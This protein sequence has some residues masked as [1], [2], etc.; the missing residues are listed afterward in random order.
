[1]EPTGA[2]TNDRRADQGM[3]PTRSGSTNRCREYMRWTAGLTNKHT[4]RRCKNGHQETSDHHLISDSSTTAPVHGG[5]HERPQRGTID[6]IGAPAITSDQRPHWW[7][8][9]MSRVSDTVAQDAS[10][11]ALPRRNCRTPCACVKRQ[12]TLARGD[13]AAYWVQ[14]L[15]AQICTSCAAPRDARW[16]SGGLAGYENEI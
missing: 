5:I 14:P 12:E 10:G 8:L 9:P 11:Q 1:M 4:T 7:R 15:D 16:P 13:R 2:D 6:L 3:K